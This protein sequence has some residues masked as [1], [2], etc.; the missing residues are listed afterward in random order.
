MLA[1]T[2]SKHHVVAVQRGCWYTLRLLPHTYKV[3]HLFAPYG[4]LR[5]E[6]IFLDGHLQW[7]LPKREDAAVGAVVAKTLRTGK[8]ER[9]A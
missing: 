5:N 9:V 3:P 8:T 4:P 6:I 1:F 2:I 7:L